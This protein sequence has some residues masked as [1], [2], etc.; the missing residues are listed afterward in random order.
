MSDTHARQATPV[1]A[2]TGGRRR[3][4]VG[5]S[6]ALASLGLMASALA[7]PAQAATTPRPI[8]TGWLP[9]WTSDA[10]ISSFAANADL[11]ADVSPFWHDTER[12]AIPGQ[13]VMV[14]HLGAAERASRLAVLRRSGKP[15][16][17]SITDGTGKGWMSNALSTPAGRSRHALQIVSL[18]MANGY[19]GIDL[20]YEQFAYADSQSSWTTTRGRWAAFVA[21]LSGALHARGK[22]LT[23]ALP[24]TDYWVYDFAAM[25]RYLDRARVMT[26]DYSFDSPG[27]IAPLPW[28]LS[29]TDAALKYIPRSK[30]FMGV[31]TYGRDWVV[32]DGNGNPVVTR[33]NGTKGSLADCPAGY[34]TKKKEV[35][36]KDTLAYAAAVGATPRRT[37]TSREITFQYAKRYS[38]G[39]RTCSILRE[40]WGADALTVAERTRALL[41]KG[42]AGIALWT[43]GGEDQGQWAD[44]RK[45]AWARTPI[46]QPVI[47]FAAPRTAKRGVPARFVAVVRAGG[48]PL[49]ASPV[50]LQF[51]AAGSPHWA[52]VKTSPTGPKGSVVFNILLNRSGDF[53]IA[54]PAGPGHTS[55]VTGAHTVTYLPR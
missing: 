43:V 16:I 28:V 35:S 29:Q 42:V 51:K 46:Y 17:P 47:S 2:A 7:A 53:R 9:Y 8:A 21:E 18:V 10:S 5:G 30:L 11:F 34:S 48:R 4:L 45:Q 19:D 49:A 37:A 3:L 25:G 6:V 38:A 41:A 12:G 39:G 44:L 14:N 52:T 26:Y 55:R 33:A 27:P 36:A 32:R 1:V 50:T 23:A 22:L 54:V 31:P 24:T 20:D 15:I 40:V 13:I